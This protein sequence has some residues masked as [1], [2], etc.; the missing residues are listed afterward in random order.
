MTHLTK[1]NI[2][3]PFSHKNV[4]VGYVSVIQE[5]IIQDPQHWLKRENLSVIKRTGFQKDEVGGFEVRDAGYG[6]LQRQ[7]LQVKLLVIHGSAEKQGRHA[8][9]F[10]AKKRIGTG[11]L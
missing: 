8:L 3:F 6:V 2:I 11:T 10:F 4:Q 9:A 5:E 7:I 1:G